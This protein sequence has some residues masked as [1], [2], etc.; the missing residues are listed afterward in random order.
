MIDV[1]IN[2]LSVCYVYSFRAEQQR[3]EAR[4][5]ENPGTGVTIKPKNLKLSDMGVRKLGNRQVLGQ[6]GR[7]PA[8]AGGWWWWCRWWCR[9]WFRW[10]WRLAG[11][12]HRTPA[13]IS[14]DRPT[15]TAP[16]L[17]SCH[18]SSQTFVFYNSVLSISLSSCCVD[19]IIILAMKWIS[20]SD[21]KIIASF[22]IWIDVDA[23]FLLEK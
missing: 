7:M 18:S 9:R 4:R 22:F 17:E 12:R 5:W 1:I 10:W 16:W 23:L 19:I 11:R 6:T 8:T 3:R 20:V 2:H 15:D 21:P 14:Y 13:L